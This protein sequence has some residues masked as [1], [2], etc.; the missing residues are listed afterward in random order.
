[1]AAAPA[2]QCRRRRSER[3]TDT[4]PGAAKAKAKKH[5]AKAWVTCSTDAQEQR[6]PELPLGWGCAIAPHEQQPRQGR[7]HGE[8]GDSYLYAA[9][10]WHEIRRVCLLRVKRT[11]M[12]RRGKFGF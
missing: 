5:A 10:L 9:E 6:Q 12:L 7:K 3:G 4:A 2:F 11:A 1:M 8:P